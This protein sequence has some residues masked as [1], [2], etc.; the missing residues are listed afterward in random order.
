MFI[1][2][3]KFPNASEKDKTKNGCNINS[4]KYIYLGQPK[5]VVPGPGSSEPN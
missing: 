2:N 3:V 1:S 5:Y 4:W